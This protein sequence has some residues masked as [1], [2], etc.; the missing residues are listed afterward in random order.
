MPTIMTLG[1]R[2]LALLRRIA[3]REVYWACYGPPL[4]RLIEAGLAAVSGATTDH[5]IGSI[6]LMFCEVTPTEKGRE[7][8]DLD[9]QAPIRIPAP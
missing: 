1:P 2:E 4:D 6:P 8:L 9:I 7:V 5:P 3:N